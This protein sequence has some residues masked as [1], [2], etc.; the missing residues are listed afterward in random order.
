MEASVRVDAL[1]NRLYIEPVLG[2]G[3]PI[4]DLPDLKHIEKYI[5]PGD[6]EK[7]KFDFDFWGVQNYT[8]TVV[9]NFSFVPII[10]AIN[11]SEHK[12][13]NEFA[14]TNFE[15]YPEAIYQVIKKIAAYPNVS[16][17]VI[18]ENG[19]AF[20]DEMV[21]GEIHDVNRLKF[22][23]DNLKEVLRA[24][25]EGINIGGYFIWSFMDNF[26]W[27]DGYSARFGIVGVDY[28][29]QQRTIK[30]SGK[31]YQEFLSE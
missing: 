25:K 2:L 9:K 28:N 22:I 17:I 8:R 1:L 31:W 15:V 20:P 5:Q 27:A 4:K 21:N 10:H 7:L 6:E 11:I 14:S 23:Q 3:Y 13:G 18:T 24:K 12:N 16:K 29:T 26:E 30:D 19:A